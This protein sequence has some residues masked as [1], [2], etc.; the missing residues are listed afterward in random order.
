[1]TYWMDPDKAKSMSEALDTA[2]QFAAQSTADKARVEV[3][4]AGVSLSLEWRV[5][6][7]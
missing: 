4:S 3:T 6:D 5:E 7:E 1:M 2:Y